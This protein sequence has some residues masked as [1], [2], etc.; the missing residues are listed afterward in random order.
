MS[1]IRRIAMATVGLAAVGT[2]SLSLAP[3]ASAA[4]TPTTGAV[5]APS[6]QAVLAAQT[7]ELQCG[8]NNWIG[9]LV[10]DNPPGGADFHQA[11]VNH[12]TC[13][14]V[15]STTPRATCDAAFRSD[16]YAACAA[17][18][19]GSSCTTVA[20]VYYWAVREYGE[21]YYDGSGDPS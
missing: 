19:A 5:P 6:V 9:Y 16:M 10:P 17:A 3:S 14:S 4:E 7:E 15:G 13:Y 2:V 21:D 8:P 18:G 1:V 12:D 11:C 20:N